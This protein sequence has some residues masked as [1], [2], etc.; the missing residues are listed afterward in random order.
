MWRWLTETEKIPP[1]RIVLLGRSLGSG[2]TAQLATEVKPGAV[3]L[4]SAFRSMS[5]MASAKLRIVPT[6][7]LLRHRFDTESKIA[8]IHA[9]I[10]FV[11]SKDD[12]LVPYAHGQWLY[13]HAKT[14]TCRA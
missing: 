8:D 6:S 2:V 10:L 13:G 9:P 12:Q 5:R 7:L 3:V 11:H 4:E 1:Q 14:P